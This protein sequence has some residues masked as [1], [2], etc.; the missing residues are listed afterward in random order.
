MWTQREIIFFMVRL[1]NTD[2]KGDDIFIFD[3]WYIM[4][5][6]KG[7]ILSGVL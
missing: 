1:L 3:F 5:L 4:L 7:F 6:K 2:L